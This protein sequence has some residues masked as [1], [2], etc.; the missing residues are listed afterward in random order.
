MFDV[1]T[2]SGYANTSP[3]KM[4]QVK[5]FPIDRKPTNGNETRIRSHVVCL[6]S[7]VMLREIKNCTRIDEK[8][9]KDARQYIFIKLVELR[10]L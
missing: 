1:C 3:L 9:H 10:V 2:F 8:C 5:S 7:T 4:A 6:I